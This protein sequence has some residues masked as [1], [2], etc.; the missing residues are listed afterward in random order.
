MRR[1]GFVVVPAVAALGLVITVAR[2]AGLDSTWFAFVAVWAPMT[3][4]GTASRAMRPRLPEGWYRLR[5][6]ERSG[7]VYERIGI[8][9]VKALLRRGPLSWFNPDLHLPTG[10]TPAALM[11]L[12]RRMRDAE[13]SHAILALAGALVAV[14]MAVIGWWSTAATTLGFD[15]LMNGCPVAL[16]RYNRALLARRHPDVLG[17]SE[18]A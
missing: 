8:R 12:D 7:R 6:W 1:L 16:Q 14:V 11:H 13:A 18:L 10:R 5:P 2:T 3:A 15:V 4:L 9:A 17:A